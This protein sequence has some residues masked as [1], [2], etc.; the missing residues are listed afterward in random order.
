MA[1]TTILIPILNYE[2]TLEDV[3]QKTKGLSDE[4]LVVCDITMPEMEERIRSWLGGLE[5]SYGLH[6]LYRTTERGYGS[7]VRF[8]FSHAN[9]DIV[10]VMTGDSSDEPKTVPKMISAIE[11]G[12]DIVCGTRFS[13]GG[14]IVGSIF[15]ERIARNISLLM[16]MLSRTHTFDATNGFRAYRTKVARSIKTRENSFAFNIEMLVKAAESGCKIGEVPAIWY[17]RLSGRPNFQVKKEGKAYAKWTFY[18]IS[19]MPSTATKLLCLLIILAL[20]SFGLT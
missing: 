19:K 4:T 5:S 18:A 6:V 10:V 20:I 15:K 3:L 11:K 1:K 2:E 13:K 7:A 14:G 12:A 16:R 8:G 9:G 17:N